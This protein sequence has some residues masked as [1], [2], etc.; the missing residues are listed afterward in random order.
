MI[1]RA[2][3]ATKS[4]FIK[5][6][7]LPSCNNCFYYVP[8]MSSKHG[9]CKKFGEKDIVTG[10]ITYENAYACRSSMC[11]ESAHYFLDRQD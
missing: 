6:I 7:H 8:S 11:G 1:S 4:Q 9:K 10:K 3:V 2:I 5:N